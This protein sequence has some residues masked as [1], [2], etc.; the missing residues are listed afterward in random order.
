MTTRKTRN[1]WGTRKKVRVKSGIKPRTLLAMFSIIIFICF[2]LSGFMAVDGINNATANTKNLKYDFGAKRVDYI[3][4]SNNV[5]L[6]NGDLYRS[7]DIESYIKVTKGSGTWYL[8]DENCLVTEL[9]TADIL[10]MFRVFAF[11]M[12]AMVGV[13]IWWFKDKVFRRF[14]I[15]YILTVVSVF[16]AWTNL[17]IILEEIR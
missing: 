4:S 3:D 10:G 1:V 6:E 14:N 9:T 8:V 2:M 13:I 16:F 11:F 12:I 15:V 17:V 5:H 7:S